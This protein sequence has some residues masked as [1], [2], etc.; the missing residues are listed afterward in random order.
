M[1]DPSIDVTVIGSGVAGREREREREREDVSPLKSQSQS[2][3]ANKPSLS[4][5]ALSRRQNLP[6]PSI[7]QNCQNQSSRKSWMLSIN[8]TPLW[9]K[10]TTL[11]IRLVNATMSIDLCIICANLRFLA[12]TLQQ[13]A[14][15]NSR[16][17]PK[18]THRRSKS[19][20]SKSDKKLTATENILKEAKKV[21]ERM[22]RLPKNRSRL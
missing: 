14:S 20:L 21:S 2:S 11:S 3:H 18:R 7:C 4:S 6:C 16:E 22:L 13:P 19:K 17:R 15:K 12:C 8:A 10:P 1:Y 5:P 9:M